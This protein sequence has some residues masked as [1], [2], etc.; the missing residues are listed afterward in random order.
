LGYDVIRT[1]DFTWNT[2]GNFSTF[3]VKLTKLDPSLQ[4]SYVGATNLGTPGQEQTQLTRAVEGE[5]IGILWGWVYKGVDESGKYILED[6]NTDGK[7]DASDQTIIGNG[8]PQFQYGWSNTFRYKNF[9][10]NF[11][12]RGSV[13]HDLINTYR[14][15]YENP[16][17][18][19]SYNVVNTKFFNPAVTDGQ[20]FSSLFVENASFVKLDNATLGYT[21]PLANKGMVRSLRWYITGQNLFLITDY[22]G[23][24]PEVSFA[25]VTVDNKGVVTTNVLAPG[26]D[27]RE[28]WVFTRSFTLGVNIQF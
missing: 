21:L 16:N 18:A 24:D 9:D 4:G 7:I 6:R 1:N 10:F 2:G 12:L 8:L 19:S 17:V 15:F 5:K 26:V 20:V 25:D 27:R 3:D 14:A 22:T 28:N 11:L 23:V 13:G